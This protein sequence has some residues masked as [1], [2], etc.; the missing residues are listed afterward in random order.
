MKDEVFAIK[1]E[2]MFIIQ[3]NSG[4]KAFA[5]IGFNECLV[6]KGFRVLED[7]SGTLF[8]SMPMEKAKDGKWY[9]TIRCLKHTL[10]EH[11][12]SVVLEAYNEQRTGQTVN[13]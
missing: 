12:T 13:A 5:D 2:R 11:I 8:V 1:V 7:K 6:I 4:I 10:R 9:E 3:K